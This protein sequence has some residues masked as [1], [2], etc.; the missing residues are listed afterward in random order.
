VSSNQLVRWWMRERFYGWWAGDTLGTLMQT[1]QRQGLV[2]FR[3]ALLDT[4]K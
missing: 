3:S 4:S 1:L 2:G